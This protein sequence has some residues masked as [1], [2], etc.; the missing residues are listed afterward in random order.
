MLA[1]GPINGFVGPG[2]KAEWWGH[3]GSDF[4]F[5]FVVLDPIGNI[6]ETSP[7][8]GQIAPHIH[9]DMNGPECAWNQSLFTIRLQ[10][11]VPISDYF[12]GGYRDG[13]RTH[14]PLGARYID[15]FGVFGG[16]INQA[17]IEPGL[18]CVPIEYS[19]LETN[20]AAGEGGLPG[21]VHTPCESCTRVDYD[22]SP[23]GEQWIT[24]FYRSIG[25]YSPPPAPE[26][27]PG[28]DPEPE[29]T[30]EGPAIYF[31]V[32]DETSGQVNV[33]VNLIGVS[34]VYGIQVE[35]AVNP[36][37]LQGTTLIKSDFND[38]NSFVIDDGF[39]EDGVWRVAAS[40]LA[41]NPAVD[42]DALAMTLPY[43]VL[44]EGDGQLNCSALA[45]DANGHAIDLNV[46]NGSVIVAPEVPEEPVV[47]EEPEPEP[48]PNPVATGSISGLAHYQN[49]PDN[50]GIKVE[51]SVGTTSSLASVDTS[52]GGEFTFGDLA[53]GDYHLLLTAPQH[54][55]VLQTVTVTDGETPVS[56]EIQLQA[57]DVDNNGRIEM[58]DILL[59]AANFG[60]STVAEIQNVDLN[61]DGTINISDLSLTSGNLD[62]VS[63]LL[64]TVP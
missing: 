51:I 13:Y 16:A 2:P 56:L 59:V 3:G 1:N 32:D 38:S 43:S 63:P 45:V 62:L 11:I 41:P 53:V 35:C 29:P 31:Q 27:D 36:Q 22:I 10:Y 61:A 34:G 9:C 5:Q 46:V 57:G 42:G 17:C 26:P 44:G 58:D 12:Q 20:I 25:G 28:E 52:T 60:L 19:N 64:D 7:G 54:I 14:L 40:R 47:T 4:R 33:N 15:R 21:W 39:G 55:P 23:A 50:A 48:E 18:D 8:S 30:P 49:R 6:Y 37:V 24:W